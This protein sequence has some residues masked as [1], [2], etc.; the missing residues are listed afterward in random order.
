MSINKE[1]ESQGR[2]IKTLLIDMGHIKG[3][4]NVTAVRSDNEETID[5]EFVWSDAYEWMLY[6]S[7]IR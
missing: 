7:N 2:D 6:G 5:N 1:L 4:L 3:V